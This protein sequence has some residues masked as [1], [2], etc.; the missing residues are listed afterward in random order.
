MDRLTSVLVTFVTFLSELVV[1]FL[2]VSFTITLLTRWVGLDRVSRWMGGGPVQSALKGIAL[3][4]ATPFCT[5]SAIPMLVGLRQADVRTAGTVGFL[6]AA[7]VL[8]PLL[9]AAF[10]VLFSPWMATSYSVVAF[11]GVLSVSLL[12]DWTGVDEFRPLSAAG[13][14]VPESSCS[15]DTSVS[16]G[17][18]TVVQAPE[19][20]SCGSGVM[21]CSTDS[22]LESG[23]DNGWEENAWKGWRAES[24]DAWQEAVDLTRSMAWHI[25]GAVAIAA[26]V[27]GYLPEDVLLSVAGPDRW[28]TIPAAALVGVPFYV[29]VEALAP[30]GAAL[31]SKGMCVGAVFALTIAGAGVNVPEFALLDKLLTRRGLVGLVGAVFTVAVAGGFVMEML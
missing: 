5:Y 14:A 23:E 3:D 9:F 30:V 28:Y 17:T 11:A 16:R 31:A 15:A 12:V 1:L 22:A 4:F 25:V 19:D 29:S 27:M 8:D 10:A 7:P 6:L 26:L 13:S 21:P 2:V 18:G 20:R 24:K